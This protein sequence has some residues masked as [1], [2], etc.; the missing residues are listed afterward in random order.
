M[1]SDNFDVE[2]TPYEK[3]T[4]RYVGK[5]GELTR[6]SSGSWAWDF[7]LTDKTQPLEKDAEKN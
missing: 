2:Q 3:P 5:F 4:L 7:Y 6:G 1:K